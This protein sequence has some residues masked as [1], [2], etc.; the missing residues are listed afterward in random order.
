[1]N[2]LDKELA[3]LLKNLRLG[4]KKYKSLFQILDAQNHDAMTAKCGRYVRPHI[5]WFEAFII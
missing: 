3:E 4:Q 1:M 5:M 2:D